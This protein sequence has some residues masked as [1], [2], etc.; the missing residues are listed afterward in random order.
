MR[1]SESRNVIDPRLLEHR[2]VWN[3]K[4]ALRLIY[5]DYYRRLLSACPPGPLLDIG[6]GSAHA[7]EFRKDVVTLDILPFPDIDV[8]ADAHELPFADRSFKSIIL[9]DVLH[10]LDR[11][12]AFLKEAA[13]VL[14]P[15]GA[16]AMIEPGIT[17]VSW[18]F[19]HFLHQE[20]VDMRADPFAATEHHADK[21]PFDS[22][23][24]SPTLMFAR[25]K[26]LARLAEAMPEL[27]VEKVD[28]LSLAVYPLSGGF[29]RWCLVPQSAVET[30]T[31]LE[32]R[33][34]RFI[35]RLM[36][37]RLFVVLKRN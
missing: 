12:V 32:D 1:E 31:A 8:V 24:A 25:A 22:N 30:G 33:M 21:D 9:L 13:R 11:P 16:L 23:Q 18:G 14:E 29:K 6:G 4:P 2:K 7:K 26:A 10:H 5:A 27:T 34:P 28:W 36:A 20:P 19:Y 17:L 15:G 37:F 35:R 3:N